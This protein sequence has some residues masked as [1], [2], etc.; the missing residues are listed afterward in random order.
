MK[1]VKKEK[2]LEDLKALFQDPIELEVLARRYLELREFRKLALENGQEPRAFDR[3]FAENPDFEDQ[4]LNI[5]SKCSSQVTRRT[6][7]VE[8][9]QTVKAISDIACHADFDTL[10]DPG[11][12]AKIKACGIMVQFAAKAGIISPSMVQEEADDIEKIWKEIEREKKL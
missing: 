1:L 7:L 12:T 9:P 8:I 3:L 6:L 5:L 10:S 2:S 4:F 11:T